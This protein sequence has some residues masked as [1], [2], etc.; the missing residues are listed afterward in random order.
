MPKK[1]S[2]EELEQR[3]KD[4]D[5]KSDEGKQGNEL[6]GEAKEE[7]RMIFDGIRDGIAV[8]DMTGKVIEINNRL[9]EVGGYTEEEIIGKRFKLLKMFSAK[10][11][12]KMVSAFTK[13]VSGQEVAPFEV[14]AHTKKG[15][16][17][18][19]EIHSFLL[20]KEGKA[21]GTVV[22]MRDFTERKQAEEALRKAHDELE[23]RV[24]ERTAQLAKAN[25]VLQAEITERKRAEEALRE[26]ERYFY[27]LLSNMHED[28]L[29]IDRDYLITDVNKAFLDTAGRRREEIIGHHCYEISHGYSE[30][31]EKHGEKCMLGKVFDTGKPFTC[32]QQHVRPDG[33]KVWVDLLVSPLRDES[34]NV[35]HTIEAVRE[36]SDLVKVKEELTTSEE[37]YRTILESIEDGYY[38]TDIRGNLTFFNDSLCK[39]SG[40]SKDELTG[41]N[42]R[43]YM[44]QENAKKVY[45]IFNKVY[46][47]G[48]PDRG[49]NYEIIIKDGTKINVESSISL[50]KDAEGKPI[51]F[52]GILR[53]IT[54][55]KKMEEE[56]LRV[57]RLESIGV[58]AGGIAHNFNNLLMGVLGNTSLMLLETE[59]T[60]PNYERLRNIEEQIQ[61]GSRLTSQLL[62]YARKGGYEIKPLSLNQMV[63][64]TSDAFA[65]TKKEIRI[66]PEL[67]E[68]IFGINADQ[69]QIEQVLMNLYVNAADAMPRGGDLFLKTMNVSQKD[70]S[71]RPYK[72]KPGNYVLL[73]VRDTG[74]GMDKRTKDRVFDPFFTTKEMGK[75]TG[76]G[77]AS[78]YG[79]VKAHGG[80]ID[81]GSKK[82]HGT[83]F[84]IYLP[85]SEKRIEKAFKGAEE[86][87]EGRGTI[88]LV[89]DEEMVLDVGVQLLK[90]L[91]YK[92]IEAK[93]GK[94]AVD[95]YNQKKGK[96]HMVLID[97]V[98]PDMGGG[99]AYDR[100]KEINP[101]V[102][103]LLSSGYSVDG[104]AT[105]ILKRGCDGFIQKPFSMRQ[106]SQS[107]R[108]VLDKKQS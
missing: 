20:R 99:E 32:L 41:M 67:A 100:M 4:L 23:R 56:L 48:K 86:I 3:A 69:G 76:L 5:K 10:S 47:T 54:E 108:Y 106:L 70:M 24:E 74:I 61:S 89:D 9:L 97:M 103:V 22:D 79:I 12:T 102:K 2:Y 49:F 91:G 53:D 63:K 78:V 55:R 77:L 81:V 36:V 26:R 27:S 50:M 92:V 52:R 40:Y 45:Q 30:P 107:I 35:T 85:A 60:H 71:D 16:K 82:G 43:E 66:H 83:T 6:L 17:K 96:I 93:G 7:L 80:Y 72:V 88:L 90:A 59:P 57:Q 11:L 105:E 37:K 44:D 19:V 39:I 101:N 46:N 98:M 87:I 38:E 28:I 15:E 94:E 62:G 29:I 1:P 13:I 104:Q 58:L 65:E 18:I 34:G 21:V 51:G 42:N 95:I 8:L 31:C 84:E 25:E 64:E 68:D 73:T 14:V 33:S 75:G